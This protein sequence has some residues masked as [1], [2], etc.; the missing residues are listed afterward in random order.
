MSTTDARF[1][2][3]RAVADD[4]GMTISTIYKQCKAGVIPSVR[5][6]GSV[7]IP[8]VAYERMLA[9]NTSR[10]EDRGTTVPAISRKRASFDPERT[11]EQF[12]EEYSKTPAEWVEEW[13]AGRIEDNPHNTRVAI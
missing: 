10:T 4:L 5:I 7:R 1:L 9:E 13:R 2:T 6:G 8:R 11:I 3:P 12:I